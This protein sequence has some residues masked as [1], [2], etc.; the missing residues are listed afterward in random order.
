MC[1][2]YRQHAMSMVVL[3]KLDNVRDV[4]YGPM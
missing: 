4:M 2:G 3:E 1:D